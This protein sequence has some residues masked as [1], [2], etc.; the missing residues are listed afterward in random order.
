MSR[1]GL[2][3]RVG[4]DALC[5]CVVWSGS[6]MRDLFLVGFLKVETVEMASLAPEKVHIG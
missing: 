4:S 2:V 6:D 1:E 5:V 3:G